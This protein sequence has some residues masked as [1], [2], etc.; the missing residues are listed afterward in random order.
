S[1]L[2]LLSNSQV[3]FLPFKSDNRCDCVIIVPSP[4]PFATPLELGTS[5]VPLPVPASMSPLSVICMNFTCQIEVPSGFICIS[6]VSQ[7]VPRYLPV[8][9]PLPD[10][11]VL[12]PV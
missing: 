10:C 5:P 7:C 2:R 1:V 8:I 3:H 6:S 11:S 9:V 4:L 12:I